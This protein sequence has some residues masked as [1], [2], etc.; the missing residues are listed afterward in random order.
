M[1]LCFCT[2][3]LP[4]YEIP[5]FSNNLLDIGPYIGLGIIHVFLFRHD[6]AEFLRKKIF[7]GIGFPS[8]SFRSE[9]LVF[10]RSSRLHGANLFNSIYR[11]W[12]GLSNLA[13][14]ACVLF[15]G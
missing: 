14:N 4:A 3:F 10:Q 11:A 6:R 2:L 8:F 1:R 9:R 15:I 7:A 12:A 5:G 13:A